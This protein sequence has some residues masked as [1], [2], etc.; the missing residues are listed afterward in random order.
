MTPPTRFPL[1]AFLLLAASVPARA[2][3]TQEHKLT[4][5]DA[6]AGDDF[7]WSVALSGDAALVGAWADDDAGPASGAAYV[8][9]YDAGSGQWAEA[10]KLT[11]GDA[12]G[13]ANF[14]WAVA[15][16]GDV[17][18]VGAGFDDDNGPGAGAAY[19]FRYDAGAGAW[20]EEQ[21]LLASDGTPTDRFGHA[22]AVE[23]DVAVVGAA[24]DDDVAAYAGS[25]YVFRYDPGT[26]RWTEEQK[27]TASDGAY[28][29]NLG[30][31]VSI[32]GDV[33]AD[34]NTGGLSRHL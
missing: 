24:Q 31:S 19:V 17:A 6:A 21:K 15:L 7:G 1:L 4:A 14:G 8:Y 20:V 9:R 26:G 23:G 10:Q 11:A 28:A 3:W 2:Q 16:D 30:A 18:V 32:S 13:G 22:V 34:V 12:E 5:G 33:R 27:L 25:A 29:D